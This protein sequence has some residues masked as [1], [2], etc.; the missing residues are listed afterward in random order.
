MAR[1]K[2]LAVVSKGLLLSMMASYALGQ[3][4]VAPAQQPARPAPSST[5]AQQ[6]P[7]PAG[8]ALPP[9]PGQLQPAPAQPV[10]PSGRF[11]PDEKTFNFG[12]ILSS[13]SVEHIFKFKNS[14]D[15]K[16]VISS[17]TG[18]CHCT[19]PTLTKV[20]YEP[21]EAGEIK[22]I[23]DPKGKAAGQVQQR[24]TVVS[25]DPTSPTTSLMIEADVQ[26]IVTVEPRLVAFN[27]IN[28]GETRSVDLVVTGRIDSFAVTDIKF[29]GTGEKITTEIGKAEP[30][31]VNGEK[32]YRVPVK[33]I[34]PPA[35]RIERFNR[36]MIITTNDSREKEVKIPV[37][38]EVT[39]DIETKPMRV[40]MGLVARDAEFSN[41][42]TLASRSGK[43]FKVSGIKQIGVQG[44]DDPTLTFDIKPVT[45]DGKPL[46]GGSTSDTYT[47]AISG[48][49]PKSQY[50]GVIDCD[51]VTD[52]PG[53][54]SVKLGVYVVVR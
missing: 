31:D 10:G 6:A 7:L 21:G 15:A 48:T 25:N 54:E 40:T 1:P 34:Y 8:D 43:P 5:P 42:A 46:P 51:V 53:E 20:E 3:G 29:D 24:V 17:A 4:A 13:N 50:R 32:N 39:G 38:G 14:G 45:R 16:L 22:V 18:S 47:V 44:R 36:N 41:T 2:A 23:F 9:R 37:L 12:K 33:V 28:K 52:V 30:I 35:T 11:T 49:A 27:Q 26:P 19:V